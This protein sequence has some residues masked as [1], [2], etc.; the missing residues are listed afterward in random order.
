ML[1]AFVIVFV[2]CVGGNCVMSYPRPDQVYASQAECA[3]QLP[4][5][6]ANQGFD[7][8]KFEGSEI[9]CMEVPLAYAAEE[10]IAIETSNLRKKP[11]VDSDIIDTVK[12]GTTFH[13]VGR[14]G[15]WL[16][17]GLP[18]GEFGFIWSDRARKTASGREG[19]QEPEGNAGQAIGEHKFADLHSRPPDNLPL[20]GQSGQTHTAGARK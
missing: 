1:E 19:T 20:A 6:P 18:N 9:A 7:R 13:V 10:W 2:H 3:A 16:R 15:R 14:E 12:R 4:G 11:S 8:E 17:S 5:K